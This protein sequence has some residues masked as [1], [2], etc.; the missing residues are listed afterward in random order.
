MRICKQKTTKVTPFQAHFGKKPNTPLSN[1]STVPKSSNLSYENTLHHYLDADTVPVEDYLNDNGCVTGDRSDILIE[2][3]MQKAQVD[4]GRRYKG[5]HNKS[6]SRF[7]MHPK[8]NNPIPRSKN[9]LDLKLVRKVTKRSKR[10]LRGL[11]ETL[12]PGSTV[13]RISDTTTVIKEP[14]VLEVRVRNSNIAK[15]GNRAE[16]NTDLRQYAQRRHL[17]Y[18]KQQKKKF[19]NIRRSSK[20][21][22]VGK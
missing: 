5:E 15:F 1:I 13:V 19:L 20:R 12:A 22:S 16:R 8:I 6:V 4:A 10:D 17:P 11:W 7:I 18:E 3:A 21:I 14:G 2:E 9:L